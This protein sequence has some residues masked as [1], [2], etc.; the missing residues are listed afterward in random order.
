MILFIESTTIF[1]KKIIHT[2]FDFISFFIHSLS[3]SSE[4]ELVMEYV[5]ILL[6]KNKCKYQL[7]QQDIG[8]VTP[9]KLQVEEIKAKCKCQVLNEITI[10]TA[11]ILQGKEEQVLIISTVSVG[12][13]SEFTANFRVSLC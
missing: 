2:T 8:I 3:N 10:G 4:C 1:H 12:S 5:D 11:A 9:Y 7:R 13:I 6:K